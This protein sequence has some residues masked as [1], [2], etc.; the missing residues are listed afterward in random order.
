MGLGI[1]FELVSSCASFDKIR[2][3]FIEQAGNNRIVV[4]YNKTGEI[5]F[6]ENG[7][8]IIPE[9]SGVFHHP[10]NALASMDNF[11]KTGNVCCKKPSSEEGLVLS[12]GH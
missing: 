1:I 5:R 6:F 9:E 2:G 10:Q 3:N 4:Y 8:E 7:K 12:G 11:I